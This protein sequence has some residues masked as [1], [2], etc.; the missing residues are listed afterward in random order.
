MKLSLL[1]KSIYPEDP[2]PP[3]HH[4]P[5]VTSIHYRADQVKPGGLFVAIPGFKAD[6]HDFV[7]QALDRGAVAIVCEKPVR[8][9]IP[10]FRV[11]N[12]R[13]A[14]SALASA[15]YGHPSGKLVITGVTGTN[16]KTT[17][18]YLLERIL[19]TAGHDTGI[20][21]TITCRYSGKTRDI[22]MTTPES[23][24][25]QE[26]LS[27]MANEGITHLVMEASSHAVDLCRIDH[28]DMDVGIFTNLSQDHLDYHKT[29]DTYF[30]CKKKVFTHNLMSSD[31]KKKKTAVINCTH[32]RGR[33]LS[34]I[35]AGI[36]SGPALL[37]VGTDDDCDVRVL[38]SNFS[39]T[40]ITGIMAT[41]AGALEFTSPLVG[42]YNLENILCA[43]GAALALDISLD[44][45]KQ[46][47]HTFSH[48]PG[49][50]EPIG[51]TIDRHVFVDYA[52]TPD[53]LENVLKTLKAITSGR[54][55]TVFGCGGD[56]DTTKRPQMGEIAGR[57]SD[58]TVITSDNPRSEDP[59][60]I[61]NDIL[62]GIQTVIPKSDDKGVSG[63]VIE[64]DRESAI[65][66]GIKCSRP[67][68]TILIAGK[69]HETYQILGDTTISFD[70]R[71]VAKKIMNTGHIR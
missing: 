31:R 24:D 32:H 1:I 52:H 63:Y 5:E 64:P 10:F 44:A 58:Y 22:A 51:N 34:S 41:P 54:L 27:H 67:G 37:T 50:L 12:T 69:G 65:K 62:Q 6:G 21:S 70:D 60:A 4:D 9:Q 46:G 17:T 16:G 35:I 47:I 19:E 59:M 18:T 55:I 66:K 53:A 29:M 15:F 13:H 61:I 23:L 25:L 56:R 28:L 7:G 38:D 71:A 11:E 36:A 30:A 45:I 8:E 43:A 49:R 20:I 2:L 42:A 33:E 39:L 3:D 68:D 40:G 57:L 26:I 48:V 14:L